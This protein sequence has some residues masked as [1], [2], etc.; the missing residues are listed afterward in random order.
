MC[1]VRRNLN[2]QKFIEISN[3]S[4]SFYVLGKSISKDEN[5]ELVDRIRKVLTDEE[6]VVARKKRDSQ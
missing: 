6:P 2:G 1:G 4:L 3:Q 5:S